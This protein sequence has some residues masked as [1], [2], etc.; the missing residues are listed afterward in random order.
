MRL[1]LTVDLS[2]DGF[3]HQSGR[4]RKAGGPFLCSQSG[5][6]IFTGYPLK[7]HPPCNPT[8]A[9]KACKNPMGYPAAPAHPSLGPSQWWKTDQGALSLPSKDIPDQRIERGARREERA[10]FNVLGHA[11]CWG[12]ERPRS[13][14]AA[15]LRGRRGV[16][17]RRGK[18]GFRRIRCAALPPGIPRRNCPAQRR[19]L[20]LSSA[21]R[22]DLF[23]FLGQKPCLRSC[24]GGLKKALVPSSKLASPPRPRHSPPQRR[25]KEQAVLARS[26]AWPALL[27]NSTLA[28]QSPLMSI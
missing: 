2:S 7:P 18:P 16:E 28:P 4:R 23:F 8:L 1:H 19:P 10:P 17:E 25:L 21:A 26:S 13:N 12:Q 15:Y 5:I 27:L 3:R 14:F 6:C 24:S 20:S 11:G 22:I 9:S